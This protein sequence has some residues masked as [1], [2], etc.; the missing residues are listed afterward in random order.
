[1]FQSQRA[2]GC[3]VQEL[4][5]VA[6]QVPMGTLLALLGRRQWPSGK[7]AGCRGQMDEQGGTEESARTEVAASQGLEGEVRLWGWD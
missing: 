1:M 7:L 3:G 6:Q 2:S 4:S 5:S